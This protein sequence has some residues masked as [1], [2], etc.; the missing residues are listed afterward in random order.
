MA[1]ARISFPPP[2]A[3]KGYIVDFVCLKYRLVVEIDDVQHNF[4]AN[5][6]NDEKRDQTLTHAGFRMLR[7]WKSEVDSNLDGVLETIDA[8]LTASNPHPA[9]FGGRPPAAGEG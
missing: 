1:K 4:E 2:G 7:F 5:T 8:V 3:R 6:A 9:A